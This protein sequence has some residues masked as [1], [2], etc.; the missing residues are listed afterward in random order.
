L[1]VTGSVNQK[2]DIQPIGGVNEKIRGFF[3][4]CRDRGLTGYQGVIIPKQNVKD[5]ML[6]S[7]VIEAVRKKQ[8]HI[9]S[10]NTIEEGAAMMMDIEPGQQDDDGNYP[11]DSLYGK[12]MAKLEEMHNYA[13]EEEAVI[14]KRKN[15]QFFQK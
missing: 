7:D 15:K 3:E 5:L 13:K 10:M 8:F 12:V 6:C 14:K 9:Y 11:T 1:A 2:G 4:L